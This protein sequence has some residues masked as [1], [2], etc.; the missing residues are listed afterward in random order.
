[1]VSLNYNYM[2]VKSCDFDCSWDE[3][4]P[5]SRVLKYN[6]A[7]VKKMEDLAKQH[8]SLA[9]KNKKGRKRGQKY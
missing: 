1:M 7:N 9:A 3:W 8:A 4:V 2:N 6:E 5:E